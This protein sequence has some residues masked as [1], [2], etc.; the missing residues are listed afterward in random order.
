MPPI[1]IAGDP[2]R[3]FTAKGIRTLLEGVWLVSRVLFYRVSEERFFEVAVRVVDWLLDIPGRVRLSGVEHVKDLGP[4]LFACNH[5]GIFDPVYIIREI[6][7]V[8]DGR[9]RCSQIMRDDFFKWAWINRRLARSCSTIP[10][11]RGGLTRSHLESVLSDTRRHLPLGVI[12]FVGGTRSRTG[13]IMYAFR[14]RSRPGQRDGD[15]RTPGRFLAFLLAGLRAPVDVVPTTITY[16]FASGDIQ[17]VFGPPVSFAGNEDPSALRQGVERVVHVIENQVVVGP[18][19]L[20][21]CLLHDPDMEESEKG[22]P[23]GTVRALLPRVVDRLADG[24]E[25]VHDE[26]R[27]DLSRGFERTLRWY[28]AKGAVREEGDHLQP[29]ARRTELPGEDEFLRNTRPSLFYW[30]QVKHLTVLRDAIRESMR[31]MGCTEK[32]RG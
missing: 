2:N 25:H 23:L 9:K 6:H 5:V 22:L 14:K 10:F 1:R 30:N 29:G 27:G 31:E 13:E 26:L 12:I 24:Y 18:Q 16:D 21:A 32:E 20:L 4:V 8:T 3:F 15:S 17:I 7:R 28:R 11:P 19:H